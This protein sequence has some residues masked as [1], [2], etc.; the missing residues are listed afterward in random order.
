M[1]EIKVFLSPNFSGEEF[2]DSVTGIVFRNHRNIE[3][4]TILLDGIN[5][6]GIQKALRLN[7]LLPYDKATRDFV[8]GNKIVKEEVEVPVVEVQ[9]PVVEIE[10]QE[11]VVE[12]VA[13]AVEEKPAK[14]PASRKKNTKKAE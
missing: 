13:E 6:E 3:V 2:V 14:K 8:N 5:I 11:P 1:K 7:V 9:E 4:R 10:V 12:V